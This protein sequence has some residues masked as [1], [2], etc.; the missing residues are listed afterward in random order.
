V[1]TVLEG[2]K[3]Q[4]FE[5]ELKGW[6]EANICDYKDYDVLFINIIS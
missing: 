4:A 6:L 5:N 2:K 1:L 3:K